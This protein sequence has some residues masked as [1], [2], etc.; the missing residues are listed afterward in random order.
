MMQK[1]LLALASLAIGLAGAVGVAGQAAA[2]ACGT[3]VGN[4][5]DTAA[6]TITTDTTWGGGA[7]PGPICLE[8]PIYVSNDSVLTILEGTVVRGQPRRGVVGTLNDN[9]GALIVTRGSQLIADGTS[10]S[11][12]IMTTAA[13][14]NDQDGVCDNLDLFTGG[15][16]AA[17]K[18][19]FPG[20]DPNVI[21][22]GGL[23]CSDPSNLDC[24]IPCT[25]GCT[26]LFCDGDPGNTPLAPLD[27][28]GFSN[29]QLWG[30]L[31]LAGA[32]PT[33]L[34]NNAGVVDIGEGLVE[35]VQLPATPQALA[36]YGGSE[37][38]DNSGIVRYVSVRHAGDPLTAPGDELNGVT[39]AGVGDGTIYEYVE[40]YAN[41]DDGHEWFG[42]TVNGSHLITMYAGD[43]QFDIDQ[44]YTGS[45][46]YLF[47][48]MPFFA[49]DAAIG[50][51]SFGS[52][53]GDRM[54]EFDGV[55]GTNVNVRRDN[56]PSDTDDTPWPFPNAQIFNLTGIGA[57][58]DGTNPAGVDNGDKRGIFM[59]NGFAGMVANSII[60]NTGTR[61]CFEVD[62]DAV[63][64]APAGYLVQDN[65]TNDLL[66]L[67]SSICADT[68]A[69][70]ATAAANGDAYAAMQLL[71]PTDG[72]NLSTTADVLVVE[73]PSYDPRGNGGL[74]DYRTAGGITPQDPRP[75]GAGATEVG[76]TPQ[77][78]GLDR[79]ATYRGAFEPGA[80]EL[81]TTPWSAG[82]LGGIVAP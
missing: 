82:Y 52:A 21:T 35:G 25:G 64:D 75:T 50:A 12:I 56:I 14:D 33:N 79:S 18:D 42:G 80:A 11:P 62:T 55:D 65:N 4:A 74:L 61:S 71:H 46:Q 22:G 5:T 24:S 9:P 43:D 32:A 69:P 31:V 51:G 48:A 38:H 76:I 39:L 72:D 23:P 47:A 28:D 57:T 7:N 8:E 81:W 16:G 78:G 66:R 59:R 34:A 30:G 36:E 58:T 77:D 20:F 10:T 3:V 15:V 27:A 45:L 19:P 26:P 54:G 49:E 6:Q 17:F 1:L 44:G 63:G 60:V 13:V 67:T 2:D 37:P 29:V 53:S 73:D 40:V 70:N 68:V 41:W